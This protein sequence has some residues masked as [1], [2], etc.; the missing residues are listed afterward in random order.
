MREA[1]LASLSSRLAL[2]AGT[3][4]TMVAPGP[5]AGVLFEWALGLPFQG[6]PDTVSEQRGW[7]PAPRGID[8]AS[9]LHGTEPALE[10]SA[11]HWPRSEPL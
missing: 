7:T 6:E 2:V 1:D 5:E 4:E 10:V 3:A 8:G 11:K 9:P